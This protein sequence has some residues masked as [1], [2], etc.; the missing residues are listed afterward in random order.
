MKLIDK[1]LF[2]EEIEEDGLYL[3]SELIPADLTSRLVEASQLFI[4]QEAM[5]RGSNEDAY[6][7]R[8]TMACIYGSPF[9]DLLSIK[10]L[11]APCQWILG[12][13]CIVYTMT[14]S[15]IPPN[16]KIYTHRIHNDDPLFIS[17]YATRFAAM[18][19][20]NDFTTENGAPRFL[21]GSH[22]QSSPPSETAFEKAIT[23]KGK[24]GSVIFF[25]P[26]I[27]HAGGT[28]TT[29]KWRHSIILGMVRSWIKQRFDI[30]R[31]IPNEVRKTLSEDQSRFLGFASAPPSSIQEFYDRGKDRSKH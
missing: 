15:S 25:N 31:L 1:E 11:M 4:E 14:T 8:L 5:E 3:A 13:D 30:P 7:G 28:N 18:I 27:W 29:D 22:L 16:S 20:L 24:A 10:N 12:E 9:T 2:I 21:L 6:Y 23:I 17:S 19:M 26:R